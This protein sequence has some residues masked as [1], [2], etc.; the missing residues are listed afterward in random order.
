MHSNL[1]ARCG[2]HSHG[3]ATLLL[4]SVFKFLLELVNIST[5]QA[6]TLAVVEFSF[7]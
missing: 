3:V 5:K 6:L 7:G 2:L 4:F 1:G